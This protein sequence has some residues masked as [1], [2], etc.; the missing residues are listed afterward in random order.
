MTNLHRRLGLRD[1][2]VVGLGSMIGAGVFTV[3]APAASIAGSGLLLSLIVAGLVATAN[4]LS[5]A[6]LAALHPE[7]GGTYVYARARLSPA[8]GHLAGWGFVV[9]KTASCAAMAL[10]VGAYVWP[11]YE[12]WLAVAVVVAMVVVNLFGITRTVAVTRVLLVVSLSTLS[13]IVVAGGAAGEFEI[14][15][16][17]PSGSSVLE[18]FRAAGLMFFAFA[19]YARLATLGEEVIEPERTIPRAVPM[20]LGLVL[21]LY[22]VV[23]V[24]TVGV[25][26]LDTLAGAQAPL[27]EVA[28]AAGW[29]PVVPLVRVGAGVAATG[30]LLSL[31]AGVSRTALAMARRGDMPAVL[32]TIDS[33]RGTPWVAEIAV[34]AAA[35]VLVATLALRSALAIS[36]VGVLVY[37]ALTNA[38]ALRLSPDERRWP[39]G[40]AGA[41]L[42]GCCLLVFTLPTR[43]LIGGLI[44]LAVGMLIRF[45]QQAVARRPLP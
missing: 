21:V 3:W 34:G 33:R 5:S 42:V 30:V 15:R 29:E 19:G 17:D 1:A 39:R 9:G 6:Q 28:R 14:A 36:G 24:V 26:P 20:A 37:Y 2:V 4:A 10:A 7:S 45:I 41:G 32:T 8:A 11:R 43:A 25:V 13:L 12:R 22:L 40:V 44:T 27:A 38:S 31:V 35:V 23:G 16:L 18:V